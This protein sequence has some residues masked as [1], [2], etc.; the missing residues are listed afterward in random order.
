[1]LIRLSF[2]FDGRFFVRDAVKVL[3]NLLGHIHWDRAGVRFLFFYAV[4]GQQVDNRL[5]LDL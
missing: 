1:L 2:R 5:C 3:A 4:P